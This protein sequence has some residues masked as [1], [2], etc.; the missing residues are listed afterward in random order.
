[1]TRSSR[2]RW[3]SVVAVKISGATRGKVA[4]SQ[5]GSA[6]VGPRSVNFFACE[7]QN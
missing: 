1:M 4:A 2:T 3:L 5:L 6:E 7:F